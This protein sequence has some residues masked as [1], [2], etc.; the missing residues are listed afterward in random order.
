MT[1]TKPAA[2][3]GDTEPAASADERDQVAREARRLFPLQLFEKLS[4]AL[5]LAG[6]SR[7]LGSMS[8]RARS[9]V[10]WRIR[11]AIKRSHPR[12]HNSDAI[13]KMASGPA[14]AAST[15]RRVVWHT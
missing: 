4:D 13:S 6:R 11:S 14:P 10:T 1:D 3:R 8:E 9:T 7:L 15:R 2:P 5:G 12:I